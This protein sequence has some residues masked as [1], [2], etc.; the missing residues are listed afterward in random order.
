MTG[1]HGLLSAVLCA[2]VQVAGR[3]NDSAGD[4]TTTASVLAR[5]M[6]HFG[7]Q[8]RWMWNCW[9]PGGQCWTK[10]AGG[11]LSG[12]VLS[13]GVLSGGISSRRVSLQG[14][15]V[16]HKGGGGVLSGGVSLPGRAGQGAVRVRLWGDGEGRGGWNNSGWQLTLLQLHAVVCLL[17]CNVFSCCLGWHADPLH[18]Y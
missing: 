2:V 5:E 17:P 3:T 9:G 4:G 11:V 1:T 8:V 6:I 12:G 7:L 13:G 14:S 16:L 18:G 15:A 10:G